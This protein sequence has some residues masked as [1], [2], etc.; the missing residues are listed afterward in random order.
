M[1]ANHT[2]ILEVRFIGFF[3]GFL[4]LNYKWKLRPNTRRMVGWIFSEIHSKQKRSHK[5]I[6]WQ[7]VP[8]VTSCLFEAYHWIILFTV[9]LGEKNPWSQPLNLSISRPVR[10]FTGTFQNPWNTC[11]VGNEIYGQFLKTLTTQK[12]TNKKKRNGTSNDRSTSVLRIETVIVRFL[13]WETNPNQGGFAS[14]KG[15]CFGNFSAVGFDWD[16]LGESPSVL[17]L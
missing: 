2:W 3:N 14:P 13:F 11:K 10:S 9:F 1:R 5:D 17:L 7:L 12:Q 16:F 15:W 8:F 6:Q 4:Y